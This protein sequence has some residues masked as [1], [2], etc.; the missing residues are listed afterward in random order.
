MTSTLQGPPQGA[1]GGA[2]AQFRDWLWHDALPVWSTTGLDPDGHGFVEQ[3]TLAGLPAAVPYKRMR[4]QAR[5]IYV[6]AQ[7]ALLGWPDAVAVAQRGYDFITAHGWLPDGGWARR[8]GRDG[9]VVDP[10]ADLY[11]HAFVLFGLAWY[12]RATGSAAALDWARR[13]LDWVLAHLRLA[14]GFANTRPDDPGP[15]LQNPH[16]HLLEA[17]LALHAATGEAA[18]LAVARELVA[19]FRGHL[20]DPATATLG[21]FFD[22]ALRPLAGADG[23][24]VEPGHHYEWVWLLDQYSRQSG[25]DMTAA[26]DALLNFADRHGRLADGAV[27]DVVGR[28]GRVRQA[29]TRLWPQT[30]Q[31]KARIAHGRRHGR[32]DADAVAR[33]V[34]L[35]QTR[36][37]AGCPRGCWTDQFTAAG[38]P[39]V[40]KIPASSLY[41]VMMGFAELDAAAREETA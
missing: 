31:L 33:T 39:A 22:P 29:S 2:H 14:I 41:H 21:E 18:F 35:L 30:E 10:T 3:L 8:L 9:G 32:I 27:C 5:Q 17:V 40:D 11:D 19:L 38:D 24:H 20:F 13:T 37:F 36:F 26:A 16:M 28:D 34:T 4:V 7:A 25:H 15:R 12:A 23:S 1:L 6:F